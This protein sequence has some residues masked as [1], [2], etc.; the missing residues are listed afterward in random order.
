[1]PN[2]PKCQKKAKKNFKNFVTITSNDS[3]IQVTVTSLKVII[4]S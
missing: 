3:L 2:C 4:T 1:M